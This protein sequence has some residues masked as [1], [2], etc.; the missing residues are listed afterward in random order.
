M[1]KERLVALHTLSVITAVGGF[2]A[3]CISWILV[4]TIMPLHIY[5]AVHGAR[6]AGVGRR[7]T[8]AIA[9]LSAIPVA[10]TLLLLL[11]NNRL[12]SAMLAAG[13]PQEAFGFKLLRRA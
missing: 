8:M 11:V 1:N 10:N 5:F 13:I 3:M 6:A 9:L 2:L 12:A 7:V 4:L